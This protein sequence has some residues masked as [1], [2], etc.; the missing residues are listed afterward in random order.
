MINL[1]KKN[2]KADFSFR[3]SFEEDS[4]YNEK[5][6]VLQEKPLQKDTIFTK[7]EPVAQLNLTY[8]I[9]EDGEGG[10]YI[11]DQHAAMER[12]NYELSKKLYRSQNTCAHP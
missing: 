11:I 5:T 1:R 4:E 3:D 8:I 9:C 6:P 7:M 10:F 2:L 12:V